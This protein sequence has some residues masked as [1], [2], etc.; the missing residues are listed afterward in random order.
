MSIDCEY[1][2][3]LIVDYWY[4]SIINYKICFPKLVLFYVVEASYFS[5]RGKC[6]VGIFWVWHMLLVIYSNLVAS[7]L[8]GS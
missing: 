6:S 5:N 4:W 7:K 3:I 8:F 1:G 2:F